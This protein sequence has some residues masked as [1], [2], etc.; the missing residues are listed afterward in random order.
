MDILATL[1]GGAGTPLGGLLAPSPPNADFP[2]DA[3]FANALLSVT[4]VGEA[5]IPRATASV[6][7]EPAPSVP[8]L[9]MPAEPAAPIP[10]ALG[11]SLSVE[12]APHL[13]NKTVAL[14]AS[15]MLAES[16][17][18]QMQAAPPRPALPQG[19][20]PLEP[21]TVL[22]VDPASPVTQPSA[23]LAHP[24]QAPPKAAGAAEP[25]PTLRRALSKVRPEEP[26]STIDRTQRV[27]G[28]APPDAAIPITVQAPPPAADKAVELA[29]TTAEGPGR[30]PEQ[31]EAQE[32]SFSVVSASSGGEPKAA[33]VTVMQPSDAVVPARAETPLATIPAAATPPAT[34]PAAATPGATTPP[35][36]PLSA[37][38]PPAP[39]P[40]GVMA[41]AL[42]QAHAVPT[43]PGFAAVALPPE[44]SPGAQAPLPATPSASAGPTSAAQAPAP[45]PAT[46]PPMPAGA[47]QPTLSMRSDR[48]GERMGVEIARRVAQGGDE[49]LIRLDPAELGRISVRMSF[50]EG[51]SLRAVVAADSPMVAE[52]IRRDTGDLAR[53]LG[54][55]GVRTDA[56]SFRFDRNGAD[57]GQQQHTPWQRHTRS[58]ADNANT[59]TA[60]ADEG[61]QPT[62]RPL[63]RLDMMA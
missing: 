56:Q 1:S 16:A 48:L 61:Q 9:T 27:E 29:L 22:P 51:G 10:P 60:T 17:P 45:A 2:A 50:D 4:G 34:T 41:P 7:A 15:T 3:L 32:L 13:R 37:G 20:H 52:A 62:V 39:E 18:I 46:P 25:A 19:E 33:A 28:D 58:G 36:P 30:P 12:P 31:R 54:D 47:T 24:S 40:T 35:V 43:E 5:A 14:L 59:L 23:A 6:S 57:G 63:G 8:S 55:A 42:P 11:H 38:G 53:A 21:D 44:P 49:I 26:V